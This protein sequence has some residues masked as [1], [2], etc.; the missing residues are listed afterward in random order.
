MKQSQESFFGDDMVYLDIG[1]FINNCLLIVLDTPLH[2]ININRLKSYV[3]IDLNFTTPVMSPSCNVEFIAYMV[4]KNCREFYIKC[5][6]FSSLQCASVISVKTIYYIITFLI[7]YG[8]L[9][10]VVII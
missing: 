9:T 1:N 3:M 4:E 6:L 8:V 10:C 2:L 5:L 7:L